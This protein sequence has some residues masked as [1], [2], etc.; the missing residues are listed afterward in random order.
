MPTRTKP[1]PVAVP[2]HEQLAQWNLR[3]S[4]ELLREL[5]AIGQ[6][7]YE[8]E[9]TVARR[10]IAEGCLRERARLKTLTD[11]ESLPAAS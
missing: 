11:L 8:R 7:T 3:I 4:V 2:D 9:T 6:I 1:A 10:L 5:R